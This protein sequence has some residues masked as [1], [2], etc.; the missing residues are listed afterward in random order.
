MHPTK[1]YGVLLSVIT[2]ILSACGESS[3]S[4]NCR[5]TALTCDVFP[6]QVSCVDQ[7]GCRW[8]Q[9][10]GCA[11]ELEPCDSCSWDFSFGATCGYCVHAV[12]CRSIADETECRAASCEWDLRYDSSSGDWESIVGCDFSYLNSACSTKDEASCTG[13]CVFARPGGADLPDHTSTARACSTPLDRPNSCSEI[14]ALQCAEFPGCSET[15]ACDGEATACQDIG[16]EVSCV[17]QVGCIWEPNLD[18]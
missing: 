2:F 16:T 17:D 13:D 18:N 14:D 11:G 12:D 9:A 1:S 15:A 5:G 7:N 3:D 4:G 8:N 6:E 10:F